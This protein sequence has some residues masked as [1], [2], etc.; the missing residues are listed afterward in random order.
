MLLEVLALAAVVA[1]AT[2]II[3]SSC[4]RSC[5]GCP[6]AMEFGK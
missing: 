5:V 2:G 3:C 4:R 6:N 1:I